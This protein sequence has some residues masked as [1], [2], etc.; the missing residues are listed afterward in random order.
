MVIH[1]SDELY[2]VQDEKGNRGVMRGGGR[3]LDRVHV[4]VVSEQCRIVWTCSY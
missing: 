2:V 1:S 3:G 4:S